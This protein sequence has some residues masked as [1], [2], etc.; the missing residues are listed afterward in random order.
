MDGPDEVASMRT[1]PERQSPFRLGGRVAL[2]TGGA[3]GIGAATARLFAQAGADVAIPFN[4]NR[5]H[6]VDGVVRDVEAAGRRVIAAPVD[7]RSTADVD[8]FTSRVVETFGRLDI[9]VA[10]A[11][12]AR[13]LPAEEITDDAWDEVVDVNLK[14]VWRTF[15]SAIPHMKRSRYGRL[16]ATTS[17]S[18]YPKAW[19]G[20]AHYTAT[21]GGIVGLCATLAVELGP[22]GITVNSVA[23]GVIETP[24]ALDPVNSL[25]PVHIREYVA[26]IP[27]GRI[28]TAEDVAYLYLYLASE[29]A[30]FVNG[31]VFTI[32][33]GEGIAGS[34]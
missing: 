31:A 19:A 1:D 27:V 15:R 12:I 6:S 25:G 18:G 21:K 24:Q 13:L 11:G 17:V 14:G 2:I 30:G 5:E 29:E 23:P 16:L 33:G 9:V 32:D 28:G 8:A 22:L 20:H 4:P 34:E 3:S 10:N 7:L 26:Q